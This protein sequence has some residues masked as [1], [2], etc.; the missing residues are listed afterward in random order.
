MKIVFE[1]V[2]DSNDRHVA[3]IRYGKLR[4]TRKVSAEVEKKLNIIA[5]KLNLK[6]VK[7]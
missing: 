5:K 2:Y 3:T 1:K 4:L 7:K 6:L